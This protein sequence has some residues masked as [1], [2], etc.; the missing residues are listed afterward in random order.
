MIPYTALTPAGKLRRLHRLA[1]AALACYDLKD[2]QLTYHAFD[3]NLLYR[4]TAATTNGERFILRLA[5]PG[6][7]T[8]EDLQS[9]A[10]W[11]DALARDTVIPA[12]RVKVQSVLARDA[13][14][15]RW[16][17]EELDAGA[18]LKWLGSRA[19]GKV[20]S[21]PP[22]PADWIA[23]DVIGLK[24]TSPVEGAA[25]GPLE[26]SGGWAVARIVAV[27]PSAPAPLT[28]C[29]E[30]VLRAMKGARIQQAIQDAF[31]RLESAT[32][33][34]ILEGAK[35]LTADRLV[36]LRASSSEGGDQ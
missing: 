3:T 29:R 33:I 30:A 10:L 34:R 26:L 8:F 36:R 35:Q 12:P 28:S 14:T 25:V 16:F 27:E 24:G 6:W 17:R 11:L 22:F 18:Q 2:P 21:L 32:E 23:A 1:L 4:V 20:D 19:S 7:R 9:E 15:A 5:Y 31:A 13:E